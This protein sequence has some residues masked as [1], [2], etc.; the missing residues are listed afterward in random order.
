MPTLPLLPLGT[1]FKPKDLNP[2]FP[3]M[4]FMVS[5]YFTLDREDSISLDYGVTPWP[6]G[7]VRRKGADPDFYLFGNEESVERIEFL[8][9]V[10]EESC[11]YLRGMLEDVV[12]DDEITSPLATGT[13]SLALSFGDLPAT[14]GDLDFDR[15]EML[16]LGSVISASSASGKLMITGQPI[17]LESIDDTPADYLC[18]AWPEGGSPGAGTMP[19]VWAEDITAVHFLGYRNALAQEIMESRRRRGWGGRK[20]SLFSRIFGI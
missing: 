10:S 6:L 19:T 9:C 18:V 16:P 14:F 15:G 12:E 7:F 2:K 20:A 1:V 4:R 3:D 11:A 5:S 8:G 17:G 13:E